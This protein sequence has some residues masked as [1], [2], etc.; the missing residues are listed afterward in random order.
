M[1]VW[2]LLLSEVGRVTCNG[3]LRLGSMGRWL[4][5]SWGVGVGGE[6]VL[7]VQRRSGVIVQVLLGRNMRGLRLVVVS[8][9]WLGDSLGLRGERDDRRREGR[10]GILGGDR[11]LGDRGGN[12]VGL[13]L[14][15]WLLH[16]L[17]QAVLEQSRSDRV[18]LGL[19]LGGRDGWGLR[20]G[21][22]SRG[23]S[24]GRGWLDGLYSFLCWGF[25][26]RSGS[27]T[28]WLWCRLRFGLSGFRNR[29][30]MSFVRGNARRT[31]HERRT[32]RDHP[33]PNSSCQIACQSSQCSECELPG[34][35]T[36]AWSPVLNFASRLWAAD[37]T[38]RLTVEVGVN[39]RSTSWL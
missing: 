16:L 26:F 5:L 20:Y 37:D 27:S 35:I 1:E 38:G 33:L 19:G 15:I 24:G 13:N 28:F 39:D 3:G 31:D 23:R 14:L 9:G 22:G 8:E 17:R 18:L 34:G 7:T 11:W 4:H 10:G 21:C 6:F 29:L 36:T 2:S 30:A 32:C 25:R 12:G